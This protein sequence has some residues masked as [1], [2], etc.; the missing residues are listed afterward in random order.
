MIDHKLG[1]ETKKSQ[2]NQNNIN[3]TKYDLRPE[4]H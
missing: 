2:D 3:H 4:G 1:H